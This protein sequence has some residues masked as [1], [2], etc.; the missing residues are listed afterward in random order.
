[1]E[2]Y[3]NNIDE[4]SNDMIIYIHIHVLYIY[5]WTGRQQDRQIDRWIDR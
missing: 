5:G 4:F 1:M 2:S 3:S